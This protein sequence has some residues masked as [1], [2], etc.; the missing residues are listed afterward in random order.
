MEIKRTSIQISQ[1]EKTF[2]DG[3][4][5]L[6]LTNL[7]IEP[8][9]ILALL[10]PSGCGKTTLLRIIAGLEK[11]DGDGTIWFGNEN[12][13]N[14]PVEQRG[15]G[16]VFQ[17]YALFPK[18]SVA[19][20]VAYGMKIRGASS[21]EIDKTVGELLDL[22][23]LKGFEGK[24]PSELSGG[25]RQRVALARA[26][27]V[28]PRVLLLDEPLTALDE[29]LKESLRDEL[30]LL[31]RKLNITTIHVT[32][33]QQEAMCIADRMA[34]MQSG[35]IVQVGTSEDLYRFPKHPFVASFLGK[36][37]S[38]AL[39]QNAE[40]TGVWFDGNWICLPNVK[41][42]D[43]NAFV[44]PE[45]ILIFPEHRLLTHSRVIHRIFL[46]DRV[47]LRVKTI[48]SENLLIDTNSECQLQ[49]GDAVR[50][51]VDPT[52]I[53]TFGDGV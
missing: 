52:A 29:K 43:T 45:D 33:D 15:I 40:Q 20:N 48:D 27:A 1:C 31:L 4:V 8:G 37:N 11:S 34:L 44:R 41:N 18:M 14:I 22:V 3:T 7:K 38:I 28:K 19:S 36:I 51:T 30:A 42:N 16:M 9:E 5:A 25:Q 21:Q 17:H 32:H 2:S 10:G 49:I 46:G 50:L 23:D 13:S 39:T 53:M 12:V 24:Y 26:I 35:Q 6:Q 47:H